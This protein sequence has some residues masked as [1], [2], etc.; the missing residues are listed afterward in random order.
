MDTRLKDVICLKGAED[1][2]LPPAVSVDWEAKKMKRLP[3]GNAKGKVAIELKAG[4]NAND[5]DELL[6]QVM[7]ET[8]GD[9]QARLD[10]MAQTIVEP[11][12]QIVPYAEMYTPI[13]FM[14]QG[15]GD[16]EDN[17]IPIEDTVAM[18][19]ETHRDGGALF[20]RVGGINWTRPT[21]QTWDYGIEVPWDANRFVGWNFLARQMART[22]EALA[23]KR[24]AVAQYALDVAIVAA[25]HLSTVSGGVM[26]KASV[27]AV[28]KAQLQVGF[29]V[30]KALI[31][32]GVHTDQATWLPSTTLAQYPQNVGA[33]IL[34][35]L[36]VSN[37]AGIEWYSNVYASS[38]FVYFGGLPNMIGWHQYKGTMKT[39]SDVDIVNKRDLHL[40]MDADHA[41]YV[42]NS[43]SL[44]RL[45]ILA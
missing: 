5:V 38:S 10:M 3:V 29:P 34:T 26:T 12:L 6:H 1:N 8:R 20:V 2:V 25:S 45:T 24:D 22:A 13:F 16:L 42:G 19:W 27:D 11:I 28:V 4:V 35:N 36:F 21:F 32:P 40:V 41:W 17:S 39:M 31:N 44:R 15:Y 7:S 33:E 9:R 23:R 14:D 43:L 18:A 37:Y 30:A